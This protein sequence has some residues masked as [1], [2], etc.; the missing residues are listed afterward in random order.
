MLTPVQTLDQKLQLF[1]VLVA[2][3]FKEIEV[4]FPAASQTEF[5][6][7]RHLVETPGEVPDDVRLRALVPTRR[8]FL[9]RTVAALRGAKR[10]CVCTYI[11]VGDNNLRYLGFTRDQAVEQA[12]D[13]VRYL[14]SITKD[15][16]E[17]SKMTEWSLAFGMESFSEAD[18]DYASH[19]LRTV[20]EIWGATAEEPMVVVLASSLE[21]ATPNIFADMVERLRTQLPD[22][23]AVQISAHTHNDRGCAVAAAELSLLAG[24]EMVEGCLFGNGERAGNADLITLALNLYSRGIHPNLDFSDLRKLKGIFED[25]TGLTVPQRAP[26]VGEFALQAFSGGHQNVIRKGI[27]ARAKA[28]KAGSAP[29][30]DVPYLPLDPEDLG[31][32]LDEIIR[33]NSQSGKAAAAWILSR[34]WGLELPGKLQVDFGRRVQSMCEKVARE[35][36]HAEVLDLFAT[37]YMTNFR[38]KGTRVSGLLVERG[39]DAVRLKASVERDAGAIS[40]IDSTGPDIASAV[41]A[42]LPRLQKLRAKAA[43]EEM[44]AECRIH[45]TKGWGAFATCSDGAQ[46]AWGCAIHDNVDRAQAH[47]VLAAAMVSSDARQ[48]SCFG[49]ES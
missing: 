32:P 3:G 34:R 42:G 20:Q 38:A 12:I 26:Y 37:V 49:S 36:S 28:L 44:Q 19:V 43:V 16:P 33:V 40:R 7:T 11:C 35:L 22:P 39:P 48:P 18:V 45:G 29:L 4:S 31:I 25:L 47:A 1:R 27:A 15:D 6:F 13:A 14:R 2:A 41:V 10:A 24:A 8:D 5:D 21:V 9:E 30:W 23:R 46:T 17:A